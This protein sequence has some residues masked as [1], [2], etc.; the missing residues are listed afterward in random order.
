MIMKITERYLWIAGIILACFVIQNQFNNNS[1]L[2]TLLV[3]YDVES[4]IQDAQI[5]D[6][7]QQLGLTRDSAYS[8][9]FEEGRTQAGVAL[10]HKTSLYSYTDGYHAALSQFGI[11]DEDGKGLTKDFVYDLVLETLEQSDETEGSYLELLEL[12]TDSNTEEENK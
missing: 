11:A 12:L 4:R 9:G 2:Q 7:S 10:I 6:L 5:N 1:N 3:T 8:K